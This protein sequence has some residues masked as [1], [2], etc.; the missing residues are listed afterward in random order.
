M[1]FRVVFLAVDPETETWAS[2]HELKQKHPPDTSRPEYGLEFQQHAGM[3][4]MG[5]RRLPRLGAHGSRASP[6]SQATTGLFNEPCSK[7]NENA[8]TKHSTEAP[9]DKDLP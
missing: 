3:V 6:S 9:C 4:C 7:V 8:A 2:L 5:R 1:V